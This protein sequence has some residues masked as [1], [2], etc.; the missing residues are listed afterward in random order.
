MMPLGRPSAAEKK[1]PLT[2]TEVACVATRFCIAETVS[3]FSTD[4]FE[5][6]GRRR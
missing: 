1:S 6:T 5:S 2:P 3:R 4:S